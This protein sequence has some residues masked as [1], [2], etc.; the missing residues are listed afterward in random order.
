MSGVLRRQAPG[1]RHRIADGAAVDMPPSAGRSVIEGRRRGRK[2]S[3]RRRDH[4]SERAGDYDTL[5]LDA[6][7]QV[8]LDRAGQ[9]G[10]DPDT[11]TTISS[12]SSTNSAVDGEGPDPLDFPGPTT[13]AANDVRRWVP[14]GPS[15]VRRGQ[16][17]G[18][19]HVTGRVTDL[20][21]SPN[22]QRI[23]ASS[24]KGGLW[25][26]GDAGA[27]W[28]PVGNW[29]NAVRGAGGNL[30]GLTIGSILVNFGA[31]AAADHVV[32]GT[33]EMVPS[34]S[35]SGASRVGGVGVLTAVGPATWRTG[36][37]N[38]PA[39]TGLSVLANGGP[40][41]RVG[42]FR[43]VRRP[44]SIPGN[45]APGP[46]RD[47]IVAAASTGV[48]VGAA[49][50]NGY[51]WRLVNPGPADD[52]VWLPGGA[53]GRLF[54]TFN[55]FGVAF[56][57]NI[58]DPTIAG[59]APGFTWVPA[60]SNTAPPGATPIVGRASLAVNDNNSAVYMLGQRQV[61]GVNQAAVWTINNPNAAAG[62]VASQAPVSD[63]QMTNA[64][65]WGGFN[66]YAHG[67]TV[68]G[69][70]PVAAGGTGTDQLFVGGGAV[71]TALTANRPHGS[72]V[73]SLWSLN[74]TLA[75]GALAA[76]PGVSDAAIAGA[77]RAGLIGN[78]VHPD[79]HAV[80][81]LPYRG[82]IS[83]LA[84]A[85]NVVTVTVNST[86]GLT[87][88]DMVTVNVNATNGINGT[89]VVRSLTA[90]TIMYDLTGANIAAVADTGAVTALRVW[91]GCDGGVY[92]SVRSG[93]VHT[94]V[95]R[96]IGL[97]IIEA[98]YV[99]NH[100]TSR[101]YTMLGAQDNGAQ[102]RVG[103]T[104]WELIMLGDGGGVAFHPNTSQDV[105][106]QWTTNVWNIRPSRGAG[107]VR[108][109]DSGAA[110]ASSFY[111]GVDA[112]GQRVTLGT[113]RVLLSDNATIRG[114]LATWQILPVGAA[115]PSIPAAGAGAGAGV[116]GGA[117]GSVHT[118][119]FASNNVIVALYAQG[120]VQYV[121]V[122]GTWTTNTV[123]PIPAGA[124]PTDIAPIPGTNPV[125]FYLTTATQAS[126]PN[127][128]GG[129]NVVDTCFFFDAP[130]NALVGTGLNGILTNPVGGGNELDP[131]SSVVVD[132]PPGPAT[133]VYVGT[134]TG[135][136]QGARGA[137]PPINHAWTTMINGTPDTT[138]QDLAIWADPATPGAPRLLRA[139]LQSR[140]I[141]EVDLAA[142]SEPQRTYVRV[143]PRDGRREFP[144]PLSNPRLRST[145]A[146]VSA[147]A[148]PDI[149]VRPDVP[150]TPPRW[151]G[152]DLGN[153]GS[154]LT[155]QLWT[156]QTAFR[157]RVPSIVA[158]G[159]WTDAMQDLVARERVTLGMG[160]GIVN[161]V[162][163]NNVV[164]ATDSAGR[165]Y[166]YRAP[167]TDSLN[168]NLSAS[169][170]DLMELVVPR[171]DSRE[172][173]Q[174]YRESSV[175][176]VL[177]HHRD[178]RPIDPAPPAPSVAQ[179]AYAVLMWRSASS[180]A[181]LPAVDTSD[182]PAYVRSL[183][184]G[185]S[186]NAV[187]AGWNVAVTDGG[188]V[189]RLTVP[190]SARTP[191]A[192]AIPLD[193]TAGNGAGQ[194]PANHRHVLLIALA[195]SDIDQFTAVPAGAVDTPANLV[196]NWP[197]AAA[198]LISVFNRP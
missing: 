6:A 176:D 187:P 20:E 27:T 21:V 30:T 76:V 74:V 151:R 144:T 40:I 78:N 26:S 92:R 56:F 166:V 138:V 44:G 183:V 28:D 98:G 175:V 96:N 5:A 152:I 155:Y 189:Y 29:A 63:P 52:A 122:G 81:V 121:Q 128:A 72:F 100:P 198:R 17:D 184:G 107:Q 172:V 174:V 177:L 188:P 140:G 171:R 84:L 161:R 94:F 43:L 116:P 14:I 163:W 57:D 156:F 139:A 24:A 75:T 99:A 111:S 59:F 11:T 131:A 58:T 93:A 64:N 12:S 164:S 190:L 162:L 18:R 129:A 135:V 35:Q 146:Q 32:V 22:G 127:P 110:N 83:N 25:Y 153:P 82:T 181:T 142:A 186:A 125:S 79:I 50:A 8:Y 70:G 169:E 159:R 65:L 130:T 46:T 16:A 54:I 31:N 102:T 9:D 113:D 36:T 53:N 168:P 180:A 167:W 193:L 51:T 95:P 149:V 3:D 69:N 119:K 148:S 37:A 1:R 124:V 145:A 115:L 68:T 154:L 173:W 87:V 141:W 10:N 15:V 23:Y 42:I 170:A 147:L 101:H 39:P 2:G 13:V 117:L 91:V 150:A 33:G 195:G 61:G 90:T 196:R 179:S 120:V 103:E 108:L 71:A 185:G 112:I 86:V 133:T 114:T 88:G 165:L 60:A 132:Q 66:F 143:H 134:A 157:W 123:L 7:M 48:Y 158:D 191:R 77:D 118:V 105:I 178:T 160:P 182:I 62:T 109:P 137:G 41:D 80:R 192:V 4:V 104:V 136:W 45:I 89:F 55:Q 126:I 197:H 85:A 47:I 73:A 97:G 49:V 19:P 38:W 67:F 194:V 106:G 34:T